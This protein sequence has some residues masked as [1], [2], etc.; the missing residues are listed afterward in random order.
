VPSRAP[1][2][3]RRTARRQSFAILGL[4]AA[5]A[6]GV[7][8]RPGSERTDT[9]RGETTV[10]ADSAR[11]PARLVSPAAQA[12]RP[13]EGAL[14]GLGDAAPAPA[15]ARAPRFPRTA[16]DSSPTV[17]ASD[18]GTLRGRSPVVPVFGVRAA[19]LRDNFAEPRGGGTRPHQALDIM[20]P[21]GTPVLSADDGRVVKL[22]ASKAGG[23]TA[24]VASPDGRYMYYYAHLD[25]YGDDLKEGQAIR[26][27]D[28]VGFVGSTGDA[29]PE[30]PHLHFAIARVA[31]PTW[32]WT[33]TPIDPY[34]V[35]KP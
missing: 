6:C 24:Y 32:W 8:Y 17:D 4:I 21:R 15:A 9:A 13:P 7:E 35:L 12:T 28:V 23:I 22:F 31:D 18:V 1:S 30:A 5:A 33:G 29:S 20:A 3:A 2:S 27:G 11:A 34:L 25:R 10:A 16:A 19:D 14:D 26:K